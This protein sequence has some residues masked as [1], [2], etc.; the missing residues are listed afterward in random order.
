MSL[1][2]KDETEVYIKH[3]LKGS[4][5]YELVDRGYA[6]LTDALEALTEIFK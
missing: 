1:T 3:Y 5:G 4:D 6:T 2:V